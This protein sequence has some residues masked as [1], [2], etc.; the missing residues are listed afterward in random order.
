MGERGKPVE[1]EGPG[2]D[3]YVDR[4]REAVEGYGADFSFVSGGLNARDAHVG[5]GAEEVERAAV[6]DAVEGC[7]GVAGGYGHFFLAEGAGV[8]DV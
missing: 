8:V 5:F 2:V 6:R 7:E 4:G 1:G 3:G